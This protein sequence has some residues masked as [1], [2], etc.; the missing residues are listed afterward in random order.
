MLNIGRR[1]KKKD[2]EVSIFKWSHILK[3]S[4]SIVRKQSCCQVFHVFGWKLHPKYFSVYFH[5]VCYSKFELECI[6]MTA[7]MLNADSRACG[8][9][10]SG[11]TESIL[12]AVKTYRWDKSNSIYTKME[13]FFRSRRPGSPSFRHKQ[14]LNL[15]ICDCST[16]ETN[17]S[18]L[19]IKENC[20][21]FSAPHGIDINRL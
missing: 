7:T 3:E 8:S 19:N 12:M 9:L 10:T 4:S 1:E 20:F 11:G 5:T 14:K 16:M 18:Y 2:F 21:T 13:H 15:V 6:A 17:H